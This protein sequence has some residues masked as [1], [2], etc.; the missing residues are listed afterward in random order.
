MWIIGLT[1]SIGM[2]KSATA[3]LFREAG[4]PVHD[5]DAAVHAMY[6]A[7]AVAPVEEA[8]P[9]VTQDGVIDRAELSK[10][11]L[12]DPVAMHRLEAIVHPLV[13]ARETAFLEKARKANARLVVLDIPLLFEAGRAEGMDAICVVSAPEAVQ[14]ERVLARPGMTPERF[15]AILKRQMPDAEKR[16]RAHFIIDTGRGFPAARHQVDSLL[17][18]LSGPGRGNKG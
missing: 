9:G 6:R 13:R 15:E 12:D 18:G 3:G 8:F 14:R 7:E 16:R 11:V 17:R 2:G 10:R 1:G 5:A 4:V